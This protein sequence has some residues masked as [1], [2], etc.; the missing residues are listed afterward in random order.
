MNLTNFRFLNVVTDQETLSKPP[1]WRGGILADE[2]G[3]GKTLSMISLIASDKDD[4]PHS[5]GH[6]IHMIHAVA[7]HST[8]VIVPP[9]GKSSCWKMD[10]V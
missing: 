6:A 4:S 5:K 8:L 1:V 7:S 3:L 10:F 2:M 9:T